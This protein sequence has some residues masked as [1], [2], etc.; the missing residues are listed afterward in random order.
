MTIQLYSWPQST[1]TR[2]SWA[3]EELG[4]PYEYVTLDR[5]SGEH[6]GDRFLA[7]NPNAKVPALVD[8]GVS[9]FE[10]A[11]ILL[12]LGERYGV[13]RGLWPAGG[14]DRADAL[15]WTVWATTE[16]TTFVMRVIYHGLDTPISFKAE[17]RSKAEAEWARG[18]LKRHLTM[19]EK[20]LT[21]REYFGGS[22]FSLVDI[23]LA[24]PLRTGTRFGIS[25]DEHPAVKAWFERCCARP[26]VARA[27]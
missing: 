18:M 16:L 27:K 5:A 13:E 26:A 12:Q 17:D 11:A 8:D 19:L 15:S 25:L 2:V 22:A 6:K 23:A 21:G 14:Q 4:V 7:I 3:L 20:R 24:S 10:S 9:Y 1:G